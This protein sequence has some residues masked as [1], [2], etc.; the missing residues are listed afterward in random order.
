M[1]YD[2]HPGDVS[3]SL[4]ACHL[5]ALN[6]QEE[7]AVDELSHYHLSYSAESHYAFDHFQT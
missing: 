6:M 7:V 4:N 1:D 5:S 3:Y 2:N